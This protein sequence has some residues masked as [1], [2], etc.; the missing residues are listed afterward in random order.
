MKRHP[1]VERLW[2]EVAVTLESLGYEL[3]QMLFGGPAGRP[4]LTV[5]LDR[6]EGVTAEDCATVAELLSVL[7]DSLDSIPGPYD[8]V[9]SSPGWD[10]PLGKVE[11]FVRFTGQ[12]VLVRYLTEAGKVRRTRGRLAGVRAGSV[13]LETDGGPVA[14]ALA[15]ITAANLQRN[16]DEEGST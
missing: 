14:I 6:P 16:W 1:V 9:V 4:S 12:P 7:L 15:Q 8:L 5:Y 10:R 2:P 13:E 11:D 3:V